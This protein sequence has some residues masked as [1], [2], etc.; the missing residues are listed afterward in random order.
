M[1]SFDVLTKA[2]QQPSSKTND[3]GRK[4]EN[5]STTLRM[6]AVMNE[7]R[8]EAQQRHRGQGTGE[9]MRR[10][11]TGEGPRLRFGRHSSR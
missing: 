11:D 9:E 5:Q 3:A 10:G 7:G 8:E 4:E 1:R 6:N 2:D